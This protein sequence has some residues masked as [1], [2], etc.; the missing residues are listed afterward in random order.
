MYKYYSTARPISIGTIPTGYSINA[1]E[2]FEERTMIPELNRK[3]WAVIDFGELLTEADEKAYE[4]TPAHLTVIAKAYRAIPEMWDSEDCS[5]DEEMN[6]LSALRSIVRYGTATI[7][8]K[9]I[10]R[11]L[12]KHGVIVQQDK[13]N[14]C[15]ICK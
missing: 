7:Y 5:F 2:N 3:A 1:M 11:W 6:T 13:E 15:W 14:K 12:H 9:K 10:A 4:L 8:N